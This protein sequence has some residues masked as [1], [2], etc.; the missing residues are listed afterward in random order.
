MIEDLP[1]GSSGTLLLSSEA[2]AKS[3]SRTRRR[4]GILTGIGIL[5]AF[6]AMASFTYVA[7]EQRVAAEQ[8]YLMANQERQRAEQQKHLAEQA[9]GELERITT[10]LATTTQDL[11]AA[12]KALSDSQ[13]QIEELRKQLSR[14]Y[15][16][17]Q[18]VVPITEVDE[19]VAYGAIG[20]KGFDVV[21]A[22][23][24]DSR[25]K[26][27]F[28]GAND[29]HKGFTSPGYAQ[30][31][32][33]KVGITQPIA[34]LNPRVGPP[35]NGDIIAYNGGYDMFYFSIPPLHKTFVIGMTPEGI[36]ALD[37]NFGTQTKVYAALQP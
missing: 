13:A 24:E 6:A 12:K 21:R 5:V 8:Q 10:Q 32:L 16:F 2:I 31:L 3:E 7:N 37:P 35:Q 18:H 34:T 11:V 17:Q 26:L 15:D 29:A 25:M 33:S 30:H 9:R 4:V 28:N 23:L 20:P 22:A 14:I 1:L 19:K 36:L 27:P